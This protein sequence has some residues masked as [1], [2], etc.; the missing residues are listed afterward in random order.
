[1]ALAVLVPSALYGSSTTHAQD[2]DLESREPFAVTPASGAGGV[3]LDAF[4]KVE[5][6]PCYF[7]TTGDDP[8][9]LFRLTN[10]GVPVA[11]SVQRYEDTVIFVPTEL[12]EPSTFYEGTAL[13]VTSDL[14]FSFFTGNRADTGP[15]V[16]G[17]IEPVTTA[18]LEDGGLRVEVAFAPAVDDGPPGS[19][20]YLLYLSR[21]EGLA[22]PELRATARS[23]VTE[24]IT[25]AFVLEPGEVLGP[26]CI[27]VHAVDGVG[28][29]DDDGEPQCFE[30]IMGSFFESCSASGS[31]A[32][33][34]PTLLVL[35]ALRRRR[36]RR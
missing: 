22:A 20:E 9:V 15:P 34:W 12:L 1:M 24:L 8:E 6:T 36:V 23:F 10:A 18:Q 21:A 31:P 3:T 16:L 11:G 14:A 26:M 17:P 19:I 28:N 7:D 30:P 35:I 27:V 13:G 5:Y 2:C 33:L 4:I 25:M 29:V 32:A